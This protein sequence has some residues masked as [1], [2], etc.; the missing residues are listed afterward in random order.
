MH[1]YWILLDIT[2]MQTTKK[3]NSSLVFLIITSNPYFSYSWSCVLFHVRFCVFVSV[4]CAWCVVISFMVT[5]PRRRMLI[6]VSSYRRPYIFSQDRVSSARPIWYYLVEY[7][8]RLTHPDGHSNNVSVRVYRT[9]SRWQYP[10]SRQRPHPPQT[11]TTR[12]RRY[13]PPVFSSSS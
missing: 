3:L 8:D 11:T 2:S 1:T 13:H 4:F 10:L 12:E 9:M 5:L 6:S 7:S